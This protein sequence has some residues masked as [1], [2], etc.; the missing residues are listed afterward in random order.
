MGPLTRSR[1]WGR[2]DGSANTTSEVA[3]VAQ[4]MELLAAVLVGGIVSGNSAG[5]NSGGD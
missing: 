4:R 2:A 5:H 1:W 3:G